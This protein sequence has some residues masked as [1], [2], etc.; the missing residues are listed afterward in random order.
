L[1]TL[2]LVLVALAGA[3]AFFPAAALVAA[4]FL[5]AAVF[6]AGASLV[7][8]AFLA[9]VAVFGAAALESVFLASAFL[10]AGGEPAFAFAIFTGPDAPVIGQHR[11]IYQST[12]A[13]SKGGPEETCAV[14]LTLGALKDASL[15]AL[16]QSTIELSGKGGLGHAG[17]VVVCLNV[18]LECLTAVRDGPVSKREGNTR[19]DS[20]RV[21]DA[22][23][24]LPARSLSCYSQKNAS[25][26]GPTR[27]KGNGKRRC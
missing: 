1:E 4:A 5:G 23:N 2:A 22:T 26:I 10:E 8:A 20:R 7:A 3:A 15:A 19:R 11:V 6:L 9:L 16:G 12:F 18:F 25:V 21:C 14:K 24:L 17:K 13:S 27:N